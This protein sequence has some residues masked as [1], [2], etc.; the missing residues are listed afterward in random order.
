MGVNCAAMD[1]RGCARRDVELTF[2]LVPGMRRSRD[3]I[4]SLACGQRAESRGRRGV[5]LCRD[6]VEL[7]GLTLKKAETEPKLLQ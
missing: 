7:C 3:R 4:S 5:L 1:V 2:Y 6:C